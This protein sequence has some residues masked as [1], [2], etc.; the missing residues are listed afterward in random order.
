MVSAQ[1]ILSV[2][3]TINSSK[4]S[5]AVF[6]AHLVTEQSPRNDLLLKNLKNC[7]IQ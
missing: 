4:M 1:Y 7:P 2:T 5:F 3:I 6:M